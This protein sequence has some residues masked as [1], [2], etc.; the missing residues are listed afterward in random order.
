MTLGLDEFNRVGASL[1]WQHGLISGEDAWRSAA[2]R[3]PLARATAMLPPWAVPAFLAT[4][5]AVGRYESWKADDRPEPS[6]R[7]VEMRFRF[8]G[9]GSTLAL[10]RGV[11]VSGQVAPPAVWHLL[12]HV[13][14]VAVGRDTA[15][16]CVMAP[17]PAV[18]REIF[19]VAD[20][21]DQDVLSLF[22]HELAHAWLL[23][24]P[25]RDLSPEE[26]ALVCG[27]EFSMVADRLDLLEKR[28]AL[29]DLDEHQACSLAAAWGA[30]G[31]PA[32]GEACARRARLRVAR[33]LAR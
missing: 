24:T 31:A 28:Q 21:V 5:A 18:E 2:E 25:V 11:L 23:P 10:L 4:P 14:V 17:M 26:E 15:G 8:T 3:G 7:E 33:E 29:E 1:E 16:I 32:D 22:L 27:P 30:T 9:S 19:L 12:Q 20:R 13:R 6:R